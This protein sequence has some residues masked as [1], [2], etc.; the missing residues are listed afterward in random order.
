MTIEPLNVGGYYYFGTETCWLQNL[1]CYPVCG[2]WRKRS[3]CLSVLDIVWSRRPSSCWD[4]CF[5]TELCPS[6][7]VWHGI[8]SSLMPPLHS[9]LQFSRCWGYWL[10]QLSGVEESEWHMSTW[11]LSLLTSRL[12]C[13]FCVDV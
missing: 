2:Y 6:P 8:T 7:W 5:T 12:Y 11:G 10:P 9:L 4:R 13:S 3:F 1:W